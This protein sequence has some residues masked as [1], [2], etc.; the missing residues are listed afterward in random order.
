MNALSP[1]AGVERLAKLQDAARNRMP[2]AQLAVLD[3]VERAGDAG[4]W[5]DA[6][7]AEAVK[8]GVDVS[9]SM[10]YRALRELETAGLLTCD[11]APKERAVFRRVH[12]RSD[13][14]PLK[15]SCPANGRS[16]VFED[17]TLRRRL[18]DLLSEHGLQD[19][20]GTLV[21]EAGI[22]PAVTPAAVPIPAP[23][24]AGT[25]GRTRHSQRGASAST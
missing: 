17:A 18:E 3:I 14:R 16:L 12:D 24:R 11:R 25:G 22:V 19:W 10:V 2:T 13:A 6:V 23:A 5:R 4:V 20:R 15:L 8:R 1:V 21:L 7:Y 9:P